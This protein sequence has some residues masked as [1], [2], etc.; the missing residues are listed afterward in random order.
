MD[1]SKKLKLDRHRFN[2][3]LKELERAGLV[4]IRREK[5]DG[6]ERR[7][8]L[9]TD[10]AVDVLNLLRKGERPQAGLQIFPN[11]EYIDSLLTLMKGSDGELRRIASSEFVKLSRAYIIPLNNPLFDY[12]E[13]KIGVENDPIV[14]TN[15]LESILNMA[16]NSSDVNAWIRMKLVN[17][18][19][20]LA[21]RWEGVS[22]DRVTEMS[23]RV[24]LT[25]YGENDRYLKLVSLYDEYLENNPPMARKVLGLIL[26]ASADKRAKFRQHVAG[27][28][29]VASPDKRVVLME[30]LKRL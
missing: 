24:L 5:A 18:L 16:K 28:M 13:D 29:K 10:Y 3:H 11:D 22:E 19:Q 1:L 25:V 12:V 17:P 23:I 7:M 2:S 20:N 14:V 15:L 4:S 6:K 21:R 9:L 30:H 8:V 27:L 26:D